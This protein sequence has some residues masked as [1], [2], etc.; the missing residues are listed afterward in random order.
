MP[1]SS[2]PPTETTP[3]VG[4]HA[5][6]QQS[7]EPGSH[8]PSSQHRLPAQCDGPS[9]ART[10]AI[11]RHK[12]TPSNR[13]FLSRT[14]LAKRWGCSVETIKRRDKAGVLKGVH[15]SAGMVRYPL[16]E[17]LRIERDAAQ[18]REVQNG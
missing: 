17:V 8:H 13:V 4:F 5:I 1:A 7:G 6:T 18:G 12:D 11:P 9:C 10:E 14:K 16:E 3:S 15:F 2:T